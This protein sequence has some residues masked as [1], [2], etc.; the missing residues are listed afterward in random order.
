MGAPP[1]VAEAVKETVA[2]VFAAVAA[3]IVGAPGTV[4][5]VTALDAPDDAL[6]PAAF[7]ARTWQVTAVPLARPLTVIGEAEP[8]PLWVPQNAV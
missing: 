6:F 3:P 4:L 2:S 1:F 8:V 5:G 7:V